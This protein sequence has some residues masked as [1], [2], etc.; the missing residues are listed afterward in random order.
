M[1][2]RTIATATFAV[3]LSSAGAFAQD[4]AAPETAPPPAFDALG[5]VQSFLTSPE[6]LGAET[7]TVGAV[8][9]ENGTIT[10]T[11]VSMSWQIMLGDGPADAA[12]VTVTMTIPT[13]EIGDLAQDGAT[14]SASLIAAP[15]SSL[16]ISA[17]GATESFAYDATFNNYRV[18]NVTW[19]PFPAIVD[20]PERPISRF[21]PIVESMLDQSF[22]SARLGGITG[23]MTQDGST[24]SFDYGPSTFGRYSD[25]MLESF[26]TGASSSTQS[27]DG[28]EAG[29]DAAA[30]AAVPTTLTINYGA[31]EGAMLDFKPLIGLLTG[32]GATDGPQTFMGSLSTGPITFGAGDV[33]SVRLGD[34]NVSDVTIDSSRG[35]ILPQLDGIYDAIATNAEPDPGVLIELLLNTYGAF[36]LGSYTIDGLTVATPQGSGE[37]GGFTIEKLDAGGLGRLAF[38]GLSIQSPLASGSLGKVELADVAFPERQAFISAMMASVAGLEPDP[39]TILKAI[40]FIGRFTIGDLDFSSGL[41]GDIALGLFETRTG[42][43]VEAIPTEISVELQGLSF[44]AALLQNPMLQGAATALG[45]DPV[46]ASGVVAL[47]WDEAT[48]R[49]T[50]DEDVSITG[51]GRLAVN[52]AMSGIPRFVF[53]DPNRVQEAIVTAAIDGFSA[54]FEDEGVTQFA[55]STIAQQSGMPAAQYPAIISEQVGAQITMLT[56]DVAL[57]NSVSSAIS[58]FL[59]S[60][61]SLSIAANPSNPV[62]LA[63]VMGAAMTAPQAIPALLKLAVEANTPAAQ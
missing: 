50:L 39:Q 38:D 42:N 16:S 6:T 35:P 56:N 53:A 36:G 59:S 1:R 40:P 7:A 60:P 28:A 43:Y 47:N 31:G 12:D 55:L 2:L 51:V 25:G 61:Q 30:G 10:A 5:A 27:I 49:V 45:A 17:E 57:A 19:K 26:T 62:P 33:M 54:R 58:S 11:D 18:T 32:R 24:Q 34:A 29:G 37:I 52:A 48:Q 22:D 63:Q 13:L 15:R 9:D 14:Y 4:T 44:P 21:I 8:S 3:T 23:T 46:E 41:I 20:D